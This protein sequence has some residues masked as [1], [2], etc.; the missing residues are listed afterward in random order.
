[1]LLSRCAFDSL[2]VAVQRQARAVAASSPSSRTHSWGREVESNAIGGPSSI[3]CGTK[4]GAALI[5]TVRGVG[6]LPVR[7]GAEP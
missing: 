2:H 6:C 4:L 3:I 7:S 5:Q 1:M